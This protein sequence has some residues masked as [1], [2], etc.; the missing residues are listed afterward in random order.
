MTYGDKS[1]SPSVCSLCIG[2][3]LAD[4]VNYGSQGLEFVF[5]FW[6]FFSAL[7]FLKCSETEDCFRDSVHYKLGPRKESTAWCSPS[8]FLPGLMKR[9][10][11]GDLPEDPNCLLLHLSKIKIWWQVTQMETH[12]WYKSCPVLHELTQAHCVQCF[13]C[14]ERGNFSLTVEMLFP[15]K[16]SSLGSKYVQVLKAGKFAM[17]LC[18][19]NW[20]QV[21]A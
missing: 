5:F 16:D 14:E 9:C 6:V 19:N 11:M 1:V 10:I 8:A 18:Y 3:D 17:H 7:R 4:K 12:S 20:Y 15:F 13:F 21:F 2:G